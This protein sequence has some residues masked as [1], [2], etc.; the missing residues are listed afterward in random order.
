MPSSRSGGKGK[1]LEWFHE[2]Q[3]NINNILDIGLGEGTYINLIKE[4][5]NICV[6][7]S[8]YGVEAWQPYI[9]KYNLKNRYDYVYNDD[10]RKF[11][12]SQLPKLDVTIAGDVLEHMSKEEAI[13]IVEQ[14]LDISKTLIIS[15][16]IVHMPQDEVE[17]NPFEVH[18]KDDWSHEEVMDTW[19]NN[20]F[21]FYRKGKKSKLGVYWLTK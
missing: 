6:N 4:K 20:I 16:P 5:N 7:A 8:W 3:N 2:N 21:S 9:E 19:K 1:I 15:I 10:I 12:F 13:E 14:V 17:G 18:V 11:S